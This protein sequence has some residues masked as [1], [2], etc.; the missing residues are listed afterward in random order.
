MTTRTYYKEK[1]KAFFDSTIGIDM[2]G[3]Y[4]PF[5]DQLP[6][7]GKILDAGCGSGRDTAYFKSQGYDVVAFDFSEEMVKLASDYIGEPVLY[8][9][10]KDIAFEG[11]FDGVWACASIVH[12]PKNESVEVFNK[13]SYALK[14][15]G[16]LYTSFKYGDCEEIRN[17]RFFSDYTES[18]LRSV[19]DKIPS[20]KIIKHWKTPD[21]RPERKNEYWLNMLLGKV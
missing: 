15:G 5:L 6:G 8:M 11:E 4:K 1:A 2:G 14:R 19:I 3:L 21:V 13:L 10:F 20:L 16:V 18:S 7:K 12:I 17:G 9:S